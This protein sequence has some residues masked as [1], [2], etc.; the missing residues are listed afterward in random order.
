MLYVEHTF[1]FRRHPK[2]GAGDSP[3]EAEVLRE[4]DAYAAARHVE[5]VPICNR[6]ATWST[7]SRSPSTS[8]SP[9]PMR[10]GR[11]P[12]PSPAPTNCC[13]T[14]TTSSCRTSA[15][16][17]SCGLRRALGSRSRQVEA[18]AEALGPGGLLLDHVKRVGEFA[19]E[20]GP[21]LMIWA[22]FVHKHPE[23]I[24]EFG[25]DVIFLDWWYEAEHDFD[26]VRRFAEHDLAFWVCPGTSSWNCLFP[27]LDNGVTNISRWAARRRRHGADGLLVTDWG[28]FGHYNLHGNSWLPYAWAAQQ[29]WSGDEHPARFDRAFAR[30]VFGDASGESARCYRELGAVHDAGFASFNGSALQFLFF[31]DL[32]RAYFVRGAVPAALRRSRAVSNAFASGCAR[33]RRVSR[34]TRSRSELRYAGTPRSTRSQGAARD[35]L[36]RLARE[37]GGARRERSTTPRGGVQEARGGGARALARLRSLWLAR[38]R[39]SNFETTRRRLARATRASTAPRARSPRIARRAPPPLTGFGPGAAIRVLREVKPRRVQ[40]ARAMPA[41]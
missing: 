19:R 11:S 5:L 35:P 9:R 16:G 14:S 24:A 25:R 26:K 28:D 7:S 13:A 10:A 38:S 18:M 36:R 32:D 1:A 23:R 29:A 33:R 3:L 15:R 17:S 21:Q 40:H 8:T 30:V 6:S 4:L 12:A 20:H 41:R 31:D 39:P 34:A 37:A 22:D 27:R 2:I